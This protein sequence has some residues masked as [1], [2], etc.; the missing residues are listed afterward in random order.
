ME[1][2]SAESLMLTFGDD[3]DRD[4]SQDVKNMM[5]PVSHV[6]VTLIAHVSFLFLCYCLQHP[7]FPGI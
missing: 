2:T 3:K 6:D 4:G 5:L 1:V 7:T